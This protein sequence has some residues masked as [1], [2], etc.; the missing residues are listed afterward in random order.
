VEPESFSLI[1]ATIRREILTGSYQPGAALPPEPDLAA[2]FGVSRSTINRAFG[3]LRSEGLIDP[4]QGRGT[5][6]TYRPPIIRHAISRQYRSARE[7]DNSHGAFDAELRRLGLTPRSEVTVDRGIAPAETTLAGQ[8]V[9]TRRRRMF[10][11]EHPVQLATSYIPVAVALAAKVDQVD[12]GLGGIYSRMAD[13]GYGP[14]RFAEIIIVRTPEDAEARFLRLDPDQRVYVVT[15]TAY[16]ATGDVV[17]VNVMIMP[18]HRW[19]LS[20]EWQAG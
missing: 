15:R 4:Q 20:Y 11:D 1:V 19:A 2:R 8:Q 10:A 7:A 17:E 16:S 18:V 3:L 13:A 12:T 9:V 14:A 6:V 5:T